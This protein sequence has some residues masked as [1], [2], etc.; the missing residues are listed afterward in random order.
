MTKVK[1]ELEADLAPMVNAFATGDALI[2][3]SSA[4]VKQFGRDASKA[5]TVAASESGKFN[6]EVKQGTEQ[7]KGL[8]RATESV[9]KST[10]KIKEL[11]NEIKA[12]TS[13]AIALKQ[14]GDLTGSAKAIQ[15]VGKLK[16]ELKD[17]QDAISAV[18]GNVKENF[19]KAIGSATGLAAQGFEAATA[20]SALFGV[21]NE[22][23]EK[24]LLKLQ[25]IQALSRI[26]A[27]FGDIGDKI[28]AI[29]S[30]LSPLTNGLKTLYTSGNTGLLKLKDQGI[31]GITKGLGGG[32]K[33]AILSVGTGF[34]SFISSAI[35]GAKSLFAVMA[36]NPFGIILT[37]V[38][39]IIGIMVA[40]KDKIKPIGALFDLI[41][42]AISY[43]GDKLEEI[44]EFFNL[45][46]TAA[47]KANQAIIDGTEEQIA[48]LKAKHDFEIAVLEASGQSTE[49]AEKKKLEATLDRIRATIVALKVKQQAEGELEEEELAKLKELQAEQLKLIREGIVAEIKAKTEAKKAEDELNKKRA[50]EAKKKAEERKRLEQDLANFLL[51][52]A[53]KSEAAEIELATDE[54]KIFLQRVAAQKEIDLLRET[55]IKKQQLLGKGNKISADQ[56]AEFA[57]LELVANQQQAQALLKLQADRAAKLAAEQKKELDSEAAFLEAKTKL[58]IAQVEGLKNTTGLNEVDFEREKQKQILAIQIESAKQSLEIK[59]AQIAANTELTKE[60]AQVETDLVIQETKNLVAKLED[61]AAKLNEKP[62][63]SL[64][65]L[66][67]LTPE[68][69]S[70]VAAG[71]QQLI[72]NVATILT[73]GIAAQQDLLNEELSIAEQRTQT[74]EKNVTDLQDQLNRELELQKEGLANNVDALREQIAA[75]QAAKE[76][77]LQN[78]Q[79]IKEEKKKLAKQ[80]FAIDTAAQAV[81][82]ITAS[83]DIFKTYA[84]IPFI[85]IPLAIGLIATMVG[86]FVATKARALQAI[87]SGGGFKEGGY[88]GGTSVDEERGAVHGLEF[89]HTADKTKKHRNLFEGIHKDDR[90]LMEQ[91]ILDLIKD[92]GISLESDLPQKVADKRDAFRSATSKAYHSNNNRSI[93]AEIQSLK[94]E[95]VTLRKQLKDGV[96][97]LPDGTRI[98]KFGSVTRIIK[99][100]G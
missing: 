25:S 7:V 26:A 100:K 34:K 71:I 10:N 21:K 22:E 46:A 19:A 53:K 79:R 32:L 83:T 95:V 42:D 18:S 47:E 75:Q 33:S 48:A 2:D 4:S 60:Q 86:A 67:G 56:Q 99:P 9:C 44:A 20:A 70:K 30:G 17:I 77:D 66:L 50:E 28:D 58:Q 81:N 91:G 51:D 39:A 61:E 52:L 43:V 98:E 49:K 88:T 73:E 15:E 3:Q 13:Q 85:G 16:D 54:A 6:D 35:T 93:E 96:T 87:N 63:F 65:K 90:F 36:A 41:G 8:G 72:G 64:A 40:L 89:V 45:T 14:Q 97:V 94:M 38:A 29:K 27:E 23:V 69:F 92:K 76:S 55:L 59:K 82:L 78:E 24:T 12:L 11:R 1:L 84:G 31:G 80:Q 5:Y 74:R 62:K 37:V 57:T 68:E